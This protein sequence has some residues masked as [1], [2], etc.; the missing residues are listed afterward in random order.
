MDN[1]IEWLLAGTLGLFFGV[2]L[3][4]LALRDRLADARR[5]NRC[6]QELREE[7]ET[8]SR[9][10]ARA[11]A[12]QAS[13]DS[14]Q[15]RIRDQERFHRESMGELERRFKA[16]SHDALQQNNRS[17]LE[18]ATQ[19]L[20]KQTV[21]SAHL[22]DEKEKNIGSMLGPVREQ[23]GE[24]ARRM[25]EVEK[26]HSDAYGAV[27]ARITD[28][29]QSQGELR[30]E[31]ANLVKA[32]RAPQ[33]RGRWGE[34]QL[35]RVVEMAGMVEH[36]DFTQQ[37]SVTDGEGQ[38]LRPDML[39]RLP[40]EKSIVV[41]AKTPLSAYLE[42]LEARDEESRTSRLKE[43]ARQV[44]THIGQ[45]GAKSYW[46]QFDEA[47][48][49]VV[50]FLPGDAFYSAAMEQDPELLEYGVSRNVILATPT[51]LIALLRSVA[52]GWQQASLA[53]DAREISRLGRELYERLGVLTGHFSELKKGLQRSVD[54]YNR[55]V[56][57]YESRVL[58]SARKFEDLG[59]SRGE[60]MDCLE[61]LD[62][63]P[64]EAP[65]EQ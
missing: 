12:L 7:R 8:A 24:V 34:I 28:M 3:D 56:R 13:L 17:F 35:R 6:E 45:L 27:T 40:G 44:K 19:V 21:S 32:L 31:T 54:A 51:T 47:P 10:G 15:E 16:L 62:G 2:L 26:G 20:E 59:L 5:L 22:L 43:H 14:Q 49:F 53:R 9:A 4:R 38:T 30:Q 37:V 58:V 41:D 33:T 48:D 29:L 57:S 46:A 36:C 65:G 52:Y 61:T 60:T 25:Q 1:L 23:L 55:A 39:V 18:V 64:R 50:L 11:A 42:A 63:V